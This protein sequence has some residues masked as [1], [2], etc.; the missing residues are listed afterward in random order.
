MAQFVHIVTDSRR[1]SSPLTMEQALKRA[2]IWWNSRDVDWALPDE[3]TVMWFL[4]A[5]AKERLGRKRLLDTLLAGTFRTAGIS[6]ILTL[7]PAD[8][9]VFGEFECVSVGSIS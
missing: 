7:N 9:R 2:E 4:A 5:M 3:R 1:F 6:S 8:F